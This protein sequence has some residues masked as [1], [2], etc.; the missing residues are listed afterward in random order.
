MVKIPLLEIFGNWSDFLSKGISHEEA[1]LKIKNQKSNI[2]NPK[3]RIYHEKKILI[4]EDEEEFFFFYETMLEDRDYIILHAT[5]GVQAFELLK[6]K[7]GY[8]H[9][10]FITRSNVG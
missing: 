5:D 1:E 9:P 2:Q 3:L 10:G 6:R 4:V 7:T 8:R